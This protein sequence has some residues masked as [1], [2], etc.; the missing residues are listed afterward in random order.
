MLFASI[1]GYF[2]DHVMSE[3]VYFIAGASRGIGLEFVKQLVKR[4]DSIIFAGVRN[5]SSLA[6]HF[7]NLPRNLTILKC[8]VTS[9]QDISTSANVVADSPYKR[10]DVLISNAGIDNGL[11]IRTTTPESFQ[12]VLETI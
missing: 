2:I 11:P 9:D 3:T 4:P 1:I 10:I 5:P 8:D 6:K 12:H 7:D